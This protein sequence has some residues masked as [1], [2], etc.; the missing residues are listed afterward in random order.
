MLNAETRWLDA[1]PQPNARPHP[2]LSPG[3]RVLR[4]DGFGVWQALPMNLR[5]VHSNSL[6][7]FLVALRKERRGE[8]AGF[9]AGVEPLF[10]N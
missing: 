5:L 2:A 8:K 10:E 3:A 9:R 6:G 1:R 7:A 4:L